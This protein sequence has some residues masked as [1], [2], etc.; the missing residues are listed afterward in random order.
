MEP[1]TIAALAA[2][3]QAVGG[4]LQALL[5]GRKKRERELNDFAKQSPL[6]T[7][8]KSIQDYYQQALNRYSENPYQSQQY[9]IGAKNIQRATAQGL[10]AMQDRRG[11]IGGASRLAEAQM[12]GM[13][14]L[15][16]NAEA[17]RNARFG[18][19]GQASQAKAAE[20]YRAFD[21]NQM[22]PY[23]R[24]LQLKQMAAQAANSRFNA[25]LGMVGQGLGN[26]TQVGIAD[27]AYSGGLGGANKANSA[28]TK[29]ITNSQNEFDANRLNLP[30]L[31][32][33]LRPAPMNY[34]DL[35]KAQLKAKYGNPSIAGYVNNIPTW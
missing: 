27:K 12:G 26:L 22:T 5:S 24:Q 1:M 16:A 33:S 31:D 23:N 19:F 28:L 2:G 20:D 17:Q 29:S 7:P 13:Q 10:G 21:I 4:G 34:I 25:G 3:A 8:N 30:K 9:Q 14:N 6:Y 18:Q 35:Y 11:G 15:G 32:A